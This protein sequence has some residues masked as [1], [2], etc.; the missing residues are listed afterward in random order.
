MSLAGKL[1]LSLSGF[2]LI[3]MVT[4]GWILGGW[5]PFLYI[6]LILFLLGLGLAAAVDYS[7]YLSFLTMK[8]AKKGMSMGM[9]I[10][11]TLVFCVSL[12]FLSKRFEKTFDI[13]EEKINSLAPQ[14]LQ[15]L[16][17]LDSPLHIKVF[18]KGPAGGKEKET[19]KRHI[20]LFKNNSSW[21]KA[22]YYN[23]HFQNALAQKYLNDLS[24]KDQDNLFVFVEYKGNK[25]QA[26]P[27]F[28]EEKLTSALI[29]TSRRGLRAVYFLTG[30]GE[31]NLSEELSALKEALKQSSFQ[32]KTWNFL[33]DGPSAPQDT[34]ALIIAGPSRLLLTKE[35]EVLK[36]FVLKGGR[37]LLAL[38]PDRTKKTNPKIKTEHSFGELAKT[39][40]LKWTGHYVV[41]RRPAVFGLGPLS[42][43]GVHFDLQSAVT[44][45]FG[46]NSIVIFHTAS[47]IEPTPNNNPHNF[48][49]TELVKTNVHTVSVPVLKEGK[50]K[51]RPSSYVIGAL[52]LA[53]S[54]KG[55]SKEGGDSNRLNKTPK[56]AI[57]VFGDSDFMTN[58]LFHSGTGWNRDLTLNIISYLVDE[59]DLISIRPKKLKATKLILKQSDRMLVVLFSILMPCVLFIVSGVIW[60]RRRGA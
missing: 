47:A 48:A 14:T 22:H 45:S 12:A 57:A 43:F 52:A 31:R 18:Y 28:D 20:N 39:F 10:L 38:D 59:S 6:F 1:W 13:T 5:M 58:P 42:V 36:K 33:K 35:L 26:A 50:I 27:P 17:K 7:M 44:S 8:T 34:S 53:G 25:I 60:L 23:A 19:I 4:A 56:G 24:N 46:R 16:N 51:A 30:H 49:A 41:S 32:V 55:S 40:G 54:N 15:L 29:K 3:I 21:V 9:S 2:S 37:V 11:I